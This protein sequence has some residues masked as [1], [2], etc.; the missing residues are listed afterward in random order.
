MLH[1]IC[2]QNKFSEESYVCPDI[3]LI[4]AFVVV[5]VVINFLLLCINATKNSKSLDKCLSKIKAHFLN[6]I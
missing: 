2:T 6:R 5:V 4:N 3:V 1:T